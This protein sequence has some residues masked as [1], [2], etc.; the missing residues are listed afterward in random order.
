MLARA[1]LIGAL[2][3]NLAGCALQTFE[4][5]YTC[6]DPDKGHIG[7]N[8]IPDPCHDQEANTDPRC[9]VGEYVHYPIQWASPTLLWFG[10]EEQAP[11]CPLGPVTTTYE[12]HADLVAPSV[13]EACTCEP[14]T[15]ACELPS[16]LTASTTPCS[17]PGG[18]TTSF[19]APDTWS[20]ACDSTTQTQAGAAH[21]L[22]IAPLTLKE[23]PCVLGPPVPAKVPSLHWDTYARACDMA[24]PLG[25]TA[26]SICLPDEPAPA[27]FKLC[28]FRDGEHACP[29]T[30]DSVFTEAHVFY[31][32]VE[33]ERQCSP[34]TCA[35]PTG[36]ACT[37]M[38]SIYKG[39]DLTCSGPTVAKGITIS[40]EGPTC[41]DIQLPGQALGSKSASSIDYLPG[42]CSPT[43]G[44][45]SGSAIKTEPVTFC[46]RPDG[47]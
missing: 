13:C 19:N 42:T 31:D 34:C 28:I 37:A 7:P 6:T 30:K 21:S 26:R 46:C 10:P 41:L 16:V 11:E 22:T 25:V 32:G 35:S 3:V 24:W 39:N 38:V 15:G 43:G 2:L 12:G 33:D 20:G 5:N 8:G 47:F 9:A 44:D 36:S 4:G 18:S 1:P 23:N 27:D 40:S 29:T 14:P 45:A 17:M